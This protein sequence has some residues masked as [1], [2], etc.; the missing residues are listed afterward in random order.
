MKQKNTMIRKI[1]DFFS[2]KD[3]GEK[4]KFKAP[5]YIGLKKAYDLCRE[6][7]K[8]F[9]DWRDWHHKYKKRTGKIFN[10]IS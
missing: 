8:Y 7:P 6:V 9:G 5:V 2:E 3:L 1:C 10:F 4:K